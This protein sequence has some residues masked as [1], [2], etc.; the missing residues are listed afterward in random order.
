MTAIKYFTPL[1]S[2][3]LVA[4]QSTDRPQP[5]ASKAAL[6]A[7]MQTANRATTP[8]PATMPDAVQRE[9]NSGA[10]LAGLAPALETE[11]RF[12]VSANDVD[13]R[14][15]FPSLVQGTPLSVAVHPE[16]E[17]T[18]SLSLKGVTLSEAIQVV[19]DIYGYEVSREG[20]VLRV[21]PAGMRTETF[22]LNYLY[23]ERDGLSLTSVSSGRISDNNSNSNTNNNNNSNNGNSNNNS[24]NNNSN[25]GSN[26]NNNS[27][28]SNGTF[29]RSR[30]KTDF[31]GDL[32][33]TLTAII[34]DTGNGRQVVVTPQAGLVTIRAFPSELRQVRS[35]L[36]S[37]ETHLQRQVILEAKILEVTLSDD[38]Q[39]GIQ[40]E[41]VLGHVGN[42]NINFGTTAGTVGNKVT[43]T[44]GGVTSLSIKGSDF[45]TMIN[46]L[47]TQGDVDVLSS[48]RV[49]ASNNQKAVIKV[50]TDEYFVTDVSSTTVAGTTPVTTPQVELTPF[51]SGIALDVT[52]QIDKDGNVLLHVHPSVIDVK[53]QTKNIKVS[54]ESLE[55][56]LAQSEIRESDT[57]IRAA[58]GDVV[59]I[60]GLMKSENV[61]VVS[62]VPLL[63]DIPLLGEL[64]KNRSKQKKKTE[65]IILLKPTVV[66]GDTWKNELERSKTLLDR[67][68]PE[69]K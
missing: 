21:F 23:M 33:E 50:G 61:E 57:V 31:W 65:L 1:L 46:L 52:P 53:E 42:T 28:S 12:D 55:L 66:G 15:F 20:R 3:C 8:P 7:S 69:T 64:F 22:P 43:S 62:Q 26:S 49:T 18:I 34:G 68:Y 48:P 63:G 58:S 40:W 54:N 17:G 47:D 37:A 19:E 44:L 60:G 30:T 5:E 2:L 27:D 35:F 9:L 10:L 45:T 56:P 51:F 14:V 13:A 4:C 39:Q 38:F 24:G 41:N 36:N 29:I 32:K 16:V 59:V 25:N 6:A 11:R 67:W